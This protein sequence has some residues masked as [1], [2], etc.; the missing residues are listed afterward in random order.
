[1][2]R[3]TT[4]DCIDF[5]DNQFML[6]AVAAKRARQL[7]EGYLSKITEDDDKPTVHALREVAAGKVGPDV[8]SQP[9]EFIENYSDS[10]QGSE[11]EAE[12][13]SLDMEEELRQI[14]L[15]AEAE[16]KAEDE[17]KRAEE[18]DD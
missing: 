13:R 7:N 8:L 18:D 16:D 14:I 5:V 9:A 2:A 11:A 6:V 3:I 4:E 12:Q 17:K 1:M 15:A 10:E